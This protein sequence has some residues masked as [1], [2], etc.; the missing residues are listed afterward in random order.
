MLSAIIEL[1]PSISAQSI[2][3]KFDFM[4]LL[5]SSYPDL[6]PWCVKEYSKHKPRFYFKYLSSLMHHEDGNDSAKRDKTLVK[7]KLNFLILSSH[8]P[9]NRITNVLYS[10]LLYRNGV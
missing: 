3:S 8:F 9:S 5:V 4:S 2:S 10:V 6:Q 1:L 7:V